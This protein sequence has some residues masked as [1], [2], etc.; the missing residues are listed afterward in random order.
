MNT[1]NVSLV[2]EGGGFRAIFAAAAIDVLAD[3]QI[4]PNHIVS[5]SAGAAYSLSMLT[6]QANRNQKTIQFINHP[7]YCG[8][9]YWLREGNFFNW[10]FVYKTIPT[11][12]FPLDYQ[13]LEE[14]EGVLE[15][16]VTNCI[17]GKTE[18]LPI[19]SANPDDLCK[20]L[21]ATSALPF[22][23]KPIEIDGTPYLDGGVSNSMPVDRIGNKPAIVVLTQPLGYVKKPMKPRW[24]I[25]RYYRNYPALAQA[26]LNRHEMYNNALARIAEMERQDQIFVIRPK[27]AVPIGR[28]ENKP[29]LVAAVYASSRN[30]IEGEFEA[31]KSWLQ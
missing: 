3:H 28:L 15:V 20:K 1:T 30:E 10:N 9:R 24:L 19:A 14:Y 31:L 11:E 6:K 27:V 8:L 18:F 5:V 7:D 16:A 13:K 23:S 17:T 4:L 22:L 12:L 29:E 21:A 25:S 26:M 2:V